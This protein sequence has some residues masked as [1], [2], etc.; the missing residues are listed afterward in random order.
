MKER[1]M[2]NKC[3]KNKHGQ[4]GQNY[5]LSYVEEKVTKSKEKK[6]LKANR[7]KKLKAR[8]QGYSRMKSKEERPESS[9]EIN[10]LTS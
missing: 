3:R 10:E 5:R 4:Q 7:K 2:M 8:Q 9:A 1:L 6:K